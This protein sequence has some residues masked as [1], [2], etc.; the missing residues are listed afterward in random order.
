MLK[1]WTRLKMFAKFKHSSLFSRS[2]SDKEFKK[3]VTL[4]RDILQI[5][6]LKECVELNTVKTLF[7]AEN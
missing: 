5:S 4:T 1:Y 3:F 6:T 2:A 7:F